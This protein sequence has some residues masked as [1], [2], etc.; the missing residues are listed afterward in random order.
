MTIHP[1]P[2]LAGK[3]T[4]KFLKARSS[5]SAQIDPVI[6]TIMG[7]PPGHKIDLKQGAPSAFSQ[8]D[9]HRLLGDHGRHEIHALVAECIQNLTRWRQLVNL[10]NASAE[11]D[12]DFNI[13]IRANYRLWKHRLAI[14]EL[15]SGGQDGVQWEARKK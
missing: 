15:I 11:M 7:L 3:L 9:V 2:Q 4:H 8:R 1:R 12:A 5:R 6:G 14:L 13:E 10:C